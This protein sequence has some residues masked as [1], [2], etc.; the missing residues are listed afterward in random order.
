MSM[1][2]YSLTRHDHNVS[3]NVY[4]CCIC[5]WYCYFVCLLLSLLHISIQ[6]GCLMDKFIYIKRSRIEFALI[7]KGWICTIYENSNQTNNVNDCF[8]KKKKKKTYKCKDAML[9]CT[10]A[11]N[12]IGDNTYNALFFLNATT[13]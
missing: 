5:V 12:F 7:F 2:Y 9:L 10:L 11:I 6:K 8:K 4:V 13:P 1:G 3:I